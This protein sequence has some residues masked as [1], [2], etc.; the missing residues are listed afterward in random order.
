MYLKKTLAVYVMIIFASGRSLNFKTCVS[1]LSFRSLYASKHSEDVS[2]KP[3]T[4][5]EST[6]LQ[7][8]SSKCK[9]TADSYVLLAVSGGLDSMA[10][11]HILSKISKSNLHLNLEVI[12]F[13]HKLRPESDE[14]VNVRLD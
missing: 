4:A 10:M 13:N 1:K 6:V 14:E 2:S 5:I 12:S 8:L 9:L 3:S 11:L 7:Y